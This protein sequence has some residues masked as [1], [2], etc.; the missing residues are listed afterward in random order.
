RP[1][2]ENVDIPAERCG[3]RHRFCDGVGKRLVIVVGDDENGHYRTP[4]S[5]FSLSTSVATSGTLTPAVRFGGSVTLRT[6]MRAAMSTPK[7]SGVWTS[8]GF[9]YAFMM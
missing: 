4:A 5:F 2:D 1:R 7:S 9:F 3:G 6:L 8:S